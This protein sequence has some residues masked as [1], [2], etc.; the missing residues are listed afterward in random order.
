MKTFLNNL[1]LSLVILNN[2]KQLTG[3]MAHQFI[4]WEICLY[5]EHYYED[6]YYRITTMGA[7]ETTYVLTISN[8]NQDT[9]RH[10]TI[11]VHNIT[12]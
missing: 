11:Q 3:F 2:M 7:K 10:Q 5:N 9:P 1:Y 6:K 4:F 8:S 12:N